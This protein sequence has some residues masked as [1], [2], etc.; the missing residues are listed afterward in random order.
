[1]D[2]R[3]TRQQVEDIISH[4]FDGVTPQDIVNTL[5]SDE[6][7]ERDVIPHIEHIKE[8]RDVMV[9]PPECRQCGFNNFNKLL[10]FPSQC[11]ECRESNSVI[12]DPVVQFSEDV[13]T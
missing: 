2:E 1:M 5:D 8:S 13:D 6:V 11:P 10:N 4:S 12:T 7:D 3:T 9:L